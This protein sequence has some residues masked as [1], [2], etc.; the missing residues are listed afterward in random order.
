MSKDIK[1]N[2]LSPKQELFCREY[3][4]DLNGKQAAIR[5]G[6][7]A[8]TAEVKAS[9]LLSLV[10]VKQFTQVLMDKRSSKIELE[11][12]DV[13]S[14]LM[15]I[16]FS[17]I[18]SIF[19]D[20]GRIKDPKDWSEDIARCVASIEVMEE[21]QGFGKDKEF[22][23]YTKKVKFWDKTKCLELMGKHKSMFTEKLEV[24]VNLNLADRLMK[25]RERSGK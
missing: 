11:S 23:G 25:A 2:E 21:F 9:Q 8:A 13:L 24:S 16:G 20:D 4:K 3:I 6:Y 5:A 18:R 19:D 1:D 10:K 14:E 22:I 7:S 17:D 12:D 15:K